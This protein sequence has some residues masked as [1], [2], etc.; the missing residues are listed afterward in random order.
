MRRLTLLAP[1]FVPLLCWAL[2]ACSSGASRPRPPAPSGADIARRIDRSDLMVR[3]G[4]DIWR[5]LEARTVNGETRPP[6]HI[7]YVHAKDYRQGR[8]GP[9]LRLHEV[10]SLNRSEVLGRIDSIGRVTRYEPVRNGTFNEVALTPAGGLEDN[11]GAIFGSSSTIT[12]EA[13]TERRIA[14]DVLDTDDNGLLSSVELGGLGTRIAAADANG[15]QQ[16]D[17]AEFD[18]IDAL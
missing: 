5:V 17:F 15:D 13:T 4:S 6:K 18:S 9:V 7:G 12:L 14:F 2:P 10:T 1:L 11:V 3:Q 8:G 16:V